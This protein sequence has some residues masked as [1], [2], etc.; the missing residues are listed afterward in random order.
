M[1][2]PFIEQRWGTVRKQKKKAI[3]FASGGI[4]GKNK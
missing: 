4:S 1:S 2:G 3:N